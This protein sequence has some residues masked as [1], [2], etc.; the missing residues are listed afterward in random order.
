MFGIISRS[1]VEIENM[2][3]RYAKEKDS[4]PLAWER[5]MTRHVQSFS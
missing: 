2:E 1:A 5:E 3:E 4:D